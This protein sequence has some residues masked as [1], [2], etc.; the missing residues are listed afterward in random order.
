MIDMKA[1]MDPR[2]R[3]ALAVAVFVLMLPLA[4]AAQAV[5]VVPGSTHYT[6]I[7]EALKFLRQHGERRAADEILGRLDDGKVYVK[8]GIDGNGETPILTGTIYL[9]PGVV[10]ND[11]NAK[12]RATPFDP[13]K[14]FGAIV[15]LA[16]T[17]YHENYHSN[18][19]GF[20][21]ALI[22]GESGIE[23]YAWN[24]TIMAME[25]WISVEWRAHF[26]VRG[27][28]LKPDMPRADQLRELQ[29]IQ[30][31]IATLHNYTGSL[32]GENK[33]FGYTGDKDWI[34]GINEFW[35]NQQKDY[36]DPQI[37]KLEP[38]ATPATPTTGG[39]IST[40][41]TM[42]AIPT[43]PA[44]PAPPTSEPTPEPAPGPPPCDPCKGIAA[45]IQELKGQ[46]TQLGQQAK[47]A[48]DAAEQAQHDVDNLKKK[49]DGIERELNRAAGTGGSSYDPTTGVTVDSYDQ[50]NGTVKVTTRD[51]NGNITDEYIRDS[52][53]R[54]AEL[55]EQ[56]TGTRDAITKAEGEAKEMA[57][58][59]A[60]A[61]AAVEDVSRRLDDLV[62]QLEDCIKKYCSNLTTSEALNMLDLPYDDLDVL[63]DPTTFNA[64]D[65]GANDVIQQM[66]IEI[67]VGNAPGMTVPRGSPAPSRG[68]LQDFRQPR[69]MLAALMSWLR[70]KASVWLT[71][72]GRWSAD[73][74]RPWSVETHEQS[75]AE[76]SRFKQ[77]VQL[78]LTSLGQS[79]G[80]AFDLQVFNGTGSPFKLAAQSLVV[81]PLKDEVKRQVQSGMPQ[82]VRA[83]A[84]PVTAKING[85]CLEF[86]K[87]PPSAGTLFKLAGPELQQRFAP[88]RQII[89]ASRR[90]Q[91]LGQL[92]PDSNPDGYFHAIR[93]WAIWT[94]QQRFNE[95]SFADAF[96]EHT[97]KAV[98]AAKR[99]WTGEAEKAVR[100]AAPNRWADIQRVLA[101]A[102]LPAPR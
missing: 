1:P 61:K 46:L 67:R 29:H 100:T 76:V 45:Q 32:A 89:D 23:H 95:R 72:A 92:R 19:Q 59:A 6:N 52:S 97:K 65:G 82:L 98:T 44:Q 27:R 43:A 40:T 85:Y 2:V 7:Q 68:V 73:S 70:P 55:A 58:V 96:V 75:R 62:Q 78:L 81:E 83:T 93:Q 94:A 31:K 71:R 38:P 21:D 16:R 99:P 77:P 60:Q 4:A 101:M 63:R 18:H 36:I 10:V 90:V 30:T 51:R 26:D 57:D 33:Y 47:A 34:D 13:V 50:G 28:P 102:G 35:K 87:A 66:I 24:H 39:G 64:F 22:F 91:Q 48:A 37:E 41:S 11:A 79:T 80:Q 69:T 12:T 56:L 42:R 9:H 14:D 49:A 86:L 84:P 54:K 88:M 20:L 25:R 53:K 74:K 8:P 17:L 15:G 3:R 5:R